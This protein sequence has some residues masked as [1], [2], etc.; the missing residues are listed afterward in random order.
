MNNDLNFDNFDDNEVEDAIEQISFSLSF[1]ANGNPLLEDR[2]ASHKLLDTF[3]KRKEEI[4]NI[5]ANRNI[6]KQ[7]KKDL[8]LELR[9]IKQALDQK[10]Q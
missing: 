2:T 7:E 1:G 4:E 10:S 6:T 9:M 3:R 5:L 8:G